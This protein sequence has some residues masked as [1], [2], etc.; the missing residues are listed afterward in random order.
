[1]GD[2]ERKIYLKQEEIKVGFGSTGKTTR[3]E[4]FYQVIEID[5]NHVEMKL[6]NISDQPIGEP[7]IIEK[8]KLKSYIYCP[9]YFK[10]RKSSKEVTVEKHVQ[11]GDKHLEKKQFLS[12]EYEYDKA[13]SLNEDHLKANLGKGKTLFALGDKKKGREIFSKLSNID[14]LFEKENKHIF[15][16]VGIELRQRGML[17]EAITNYLKAIKFDPNDWVLYYNLGRAYYEQG[18]RLNALE[19]LKMALTIKPDFKEADEFFSSISFP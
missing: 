15:N 14:A 16:E 12:A 10:N 2:R 3:I 9:D 13:L 19:K 11:M 4:D 6:L 7:I 17:E 1:M 5:N 18:D 8:E